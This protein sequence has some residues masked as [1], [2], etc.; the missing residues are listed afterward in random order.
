MVTRAPEAIVL[1]KD[2]EVV[3]HSSTK[4][5]VRIERTVRRLRA[6]EIWR[7]LNAT[8]RQDVQAVG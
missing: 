7:D 6:E 4:F 5:Q 2:A 3:H 1:R 8:R